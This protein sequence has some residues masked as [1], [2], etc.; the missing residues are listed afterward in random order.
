MTPCRPEFIIN[1]ATVHRATSKPSRFI[2][3]RTLRIPQSLQFCCQARAISGRTALSRPARSDTGSGFACLAMGSWTV[4]RSI[5]R[6]LQ[7]DSPPDIVTVVCDAGDHVPDRR[8]SSARAKH[9]VADVSRTNGAANGADDEDMRRLLDTVD[10]DRR[11]AKAGQGMTGR[12]RQWREHLA[13]A[14]FALPYVV[15]RD[16]V[17]AG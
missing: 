10:D 14:P 15:L 7:S 1:R 8:S 4:D 17:A 5:G 6:C 3:G 2:G 13:T 9:A 12:V 11:V 16:G